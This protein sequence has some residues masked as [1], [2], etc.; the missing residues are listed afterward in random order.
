MDNCWLFRLR[1]VGCFRDAMGVDAVIMLTVKDI[2]EDLQI[3]PRLV[4]YIAKKEDFPRP[5]VVS[6]QAKRWH[7]AEYESWKKRLRRER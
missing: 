5:V 7:E 3:S 2:A 6:T 4:R 1:A